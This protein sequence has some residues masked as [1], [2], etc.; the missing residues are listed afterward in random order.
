MNGYCRYC[1]KYSEQITYAR[2]MSRQC[3]DCAGKVLYG[4]TLGYVRC[5]EHYNDN[6]TV[7]YSAKE[8]QSIGHYCDVCHPQY[9]YGR[10]A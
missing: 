7:E 5:E 4:D 10:T 2:D 8:Q 9:N 1:Q 6:A 3:P